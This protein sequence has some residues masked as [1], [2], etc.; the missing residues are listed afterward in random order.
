MTSLPPPDDSRDDDI[1]PVVPVPLSGPAP[2]EPEE[3]EAVAAEAD[4]A[5]VVVATAE[6]EMMLDENGLPM[7]HVPAIPPDSLDLPVVD[8][9]TSHNKEKAAAVLAAVLVHVALFM[10]L[11]VLLVVV[12][13]PPAS[14]ITAISAPTTQEQVPTPQKIAEPPPQQTV[15]QPMA[16]MKFMTATNVSAVPMPAIEFDPTETTLDLGSTMGAFD[17]NFSSTGAGSVV[18]FG[19]ELKNVRKIAVVMDVSRSM[20]RYLPIVVQELKKVGKD[21]PLILYFGCWLNPLPKKEEKVIPVGGEEFDK[22]WQY[23]QGR[24]PFDELH[25]TYPSLKYDPKK[26]MPLEDVYKQVHKRKDTYFIDRF[27]R[28]TSV[29]SALMAKE[30]KDADM[31]YWFADFEDN[32]NQDMAR[33]LVKK[34]KSRGRKITIHAPH[35]RGKRLNEAKQWIVEPL[36]G[37]VIIQDIK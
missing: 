24:T 18:M 36:G 7:S 3:L 19:R 29:Y 11:G 25:Q 33:E 13:G 27:G 35:D 14:E 30:I 2:A 31:V 28:D 20:T 12:P 37:E 22:F 5:E 32:I 23:W 4:D 10:L 21:S 8:A 34:F 17:A 26:P 15:S 1:A 6:E 16:S 9:H